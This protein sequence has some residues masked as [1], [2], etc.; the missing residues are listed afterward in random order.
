[1]P[2]PIQTVRKARRL[3]REL[4][5]P[6]VLVWQGLRKA[7]VGIKFRRQHPV[8]PFVLDF[9]CPSVK[10]GIEIDGVAHDMGRNPQRDAERDA[11]LRERGIRTIRIPARDVLRDVDG[12]VAAIVVACRER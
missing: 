8:G 1:M 7:P 11:W 10:A 6:E 4:T 5:L 9:Y 3:R 2:P 12:V